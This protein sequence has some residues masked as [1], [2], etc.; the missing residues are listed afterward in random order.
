MRYYESLYIVNPNF[1]QERL[2]EVMQEVAEKVG[3]Y[4]F[5]IIN[6]RIWGKKRLAYA[7]QKHKYGTYVLL[8]FETEEVTRLADFERYMVLNKAVLRNQTVRLEHR[9]EVFED[10]DKETVA[11]PQKESKPSSPETDDTK[12]R[13]ED[14]A[15]PGDGDDHQDEEPEDSVEETNAPEEALKEEGQE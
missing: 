8:Q 12:K 5:K 7:I 14:Q 11:E 4:G 2:N 13:E 15:E 9:P 6:H 1:E 3:G 10:T